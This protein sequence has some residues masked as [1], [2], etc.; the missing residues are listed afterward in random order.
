MIASEVK[1]IVLACSTTAEHEKRLLWI[2][3][4]LQKVFK[5]GR[6][7]INNVMVQRVRC[8]SERQR[9]RKNLKSQLL[10]IQAAVAVSRLI[11]YC[12]YEITS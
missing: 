6:P 8:V 10:M 12:N 2:D 3:I 11:N 4:R 9:R 7:C 1:D 5:D